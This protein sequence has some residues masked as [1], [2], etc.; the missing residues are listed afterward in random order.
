MFEI[1]RNGDIANSSK[2]YLSTI[3]TSQSK[4]IEGIKIIPIS[5][6]KDSDS[7]KLWEVEEYYKID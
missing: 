6:L 2:K 3:C 4:E 1:Y 7:E 5:E